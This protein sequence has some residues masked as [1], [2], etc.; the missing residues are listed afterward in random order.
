MLLFSGCEEGCA[1]I[2]LPAQEIKILGKDIDSDVIAGI[3]MFML[4]Q[5][6]KCLEVT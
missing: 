1:V 3:R 4:Y 5:G 6:Y 2:L